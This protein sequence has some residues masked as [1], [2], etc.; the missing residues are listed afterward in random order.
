MKEEKENLKKE[1]ERVHNE[2]MKFLEEKEKALE[3]EKRIASS[4]YDSNVDEK[5]QSLRTE[6]EKKINSA[7]NERDRDRLINQI[8]GPTIV[9]PKPVCNDVVLEADLDGD[10]EYWIQNTTPMNENVSDTS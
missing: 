3:E 1:Q 8:K 7:F 10:Q 5:I 2:K 4:N 9:L 6:V